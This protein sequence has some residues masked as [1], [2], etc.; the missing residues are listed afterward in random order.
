MSDTVQLPG[1]S[2]VEQPTSND[3]GM[4]P[5][6][7]CLLTFLAVGPGLLLL[8]L[9][10]ALSGGP[11][12]ILAVIFLGAIPWVLL[13]M[14]F[15]FKLIALLL[16][17]GGLNYS[18]AKAAV[19]EGRISVTYYLR[20]FMGDNLIVVDEPGR[21]LFVNGTVVDFDQIKNLGWESGNKKHRLTVTLKSG[22]DPILSADLG[23]ED[24][25]KSS[26]ERLGNTLGFS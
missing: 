11:G 16:M 19:R 10:I 2:P 18:R 6:L 3:L 12:A 20:D 8:G 15:G 4:A 21:R 7:V 13:T 9:L 5:L 26:F 1:T 23:S 14:F 24:K 22:V 17:G 25:L